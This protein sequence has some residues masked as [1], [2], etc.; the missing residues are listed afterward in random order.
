MADTDKKGDLIRRRDE[1]MTELSGVNTNLRLELDNDPEEQ[2]IQI[3]QNEVA[4]TM[5]AQLRRELNDIE[6]KL[7]D[8]K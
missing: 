2:A 1:I 6:E 3:E 5:E 4:A 7:I 8:L